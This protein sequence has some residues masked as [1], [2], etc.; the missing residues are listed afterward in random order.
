[1][2]KN[3]K[4]LRQNETTA[5]RIYEFTEM[6]GISTALHVGPGMYQVTVVEAHT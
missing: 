5:G 2:K 4:G 6:A 1:M 3:Y